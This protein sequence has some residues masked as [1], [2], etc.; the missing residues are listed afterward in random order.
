MSDLDH[1]RA[2]SPDRLGLDLLLRVRMAGAL[3]QKDADALAAAVDRAIAGE[4]LEASLGLNGG[5]RSAARQMIMDAAPLDLLDDLSAPA[6]KAKLARYVE[7]HF[8]EDLRTGRPPASR[9][10]MFELVVANRGRPPSNRKIQRWRERI[11]ASRQTE[12][13]FG[14]RDASSLSETTSNED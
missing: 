7:T 1:P 10:L 11:R 13:G 9:A 6:I 8:K 4:P 3:N 12:G 2:A 5:W 14:A